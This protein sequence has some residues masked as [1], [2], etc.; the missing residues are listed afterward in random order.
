MLYNLSIIGMISLF[1]GSIFCLAGKRGKAFLPGMQIIAFV[2]TTS[3][4]AEIVV[5]LWFMSFT[6]LIYKPFVCAI[7][8]AICLFYMPCL[9]QLDR[10]S[11]LSFCAD[12]HMAFVQDNSYLYGCPFAQTNI[13]RL[14]SGG[15]TAYPNITSF[16]QIMM[17]TVDAQFVCNYV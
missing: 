1:I 5:S 4:I 7:I 13:C 17:T 8:I 16:A 6:R 2:V 9:A 3:T 14:S 12:Q 11:S 10:H 15:L